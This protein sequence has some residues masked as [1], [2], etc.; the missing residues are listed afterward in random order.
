MS[1]TSAKAP[2]L[3]TLDEWVVSSL[4]PRDTIKEAIKAAK[5]LEG[6]KWNWKWSKPSGNCKTNAYHDCN[7]HVECG[8]RMKVLKFG[9]KFYIFFISWPGA[10]TF[11]PLDLDSALASWEYFF[12]M[13]LS[14]TL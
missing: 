7:A 8:R 3:P 10:L 1:S 6:G 14:R 12:W 4:P 13:A 5:K 9:E 2:E 11:P